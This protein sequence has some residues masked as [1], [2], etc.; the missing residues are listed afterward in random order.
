MSQIERR[1]RASA[2]LSEVWEFLAEESEERADSFIDRIDAKF[3]TLATQ[4]L[5]G[6]ARPELG[7]RIRSLAVPPYVIFYEPLADGVLILRVLHGSRDIA[8]Q[9]DQNA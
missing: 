9:F 4:P 6:R 1:P 5:M 3:R 2:D 7:A 8:S